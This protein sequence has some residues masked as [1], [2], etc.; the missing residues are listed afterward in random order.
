M[1]RIPS[2]SSPPSMASLEFQLSSSSSQTEPPSLK[3]AATTFK[4]ERAQRPPLPNGRVLKY[5]TR[6]FIPA[7]SSFFFEPFHFNFSMQ[8]SFCK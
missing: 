8:Y 4:T 3:T 5:T 6:F 7:Y 2:R 1:D